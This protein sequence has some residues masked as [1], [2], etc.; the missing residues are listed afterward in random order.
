MPEFARALRQSVDEFKK[1]SEAEQ[2][3]AA[4]SSSTSNKDAEIKDLEK[5]LEQLKKQEG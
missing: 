3:K 1:P 5:K 4:S 2:A